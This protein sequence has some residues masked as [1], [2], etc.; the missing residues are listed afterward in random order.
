MSLLKISELD[1]V[2]I[3]YDE[4]NAEINYARLLQEAPWAKRVH[5]VKGSD[6]CH[7]A[8]ANLSDTDWFVTVDADNIVK[9][10]FWDIELDLNK[11]PNAQAFNWPGRNNINGL[12]YGNGSIKVWRKE[13]VLNMKTHEAAEEA[14]GQVDFC[15]EAGYYPLTVSYSDTI[16]NTTPLQAWRAGFREGV[17]MSLDRGVRC[18]GDTAKK[19]IWW[20]NL[21]RLK[22]WLSTGSHAQN[23]MW[24]I[25]GARQGCYQTMLTDWDITRVRDFD[26]LKEEFD[27][28]GDDVEYACEYYGK[29]L[30][31]FFENK[32]YLLDHA[33]SE[34]MVDL[35]DEFYRLNRV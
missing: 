32:L 27:T 19:A 24:A 18:K 26:L 12:R 11:Y 30:Q 22:I 6:A 20:E 7:K 34:N 23:G 33:Q 8:A 10:K 9:P 29:K 13:F 25:A 2:F 5:G 17:K 31:Q 1:C 15:W 4:P 35:F 14:K 3:S 16:I 28:I 21:H